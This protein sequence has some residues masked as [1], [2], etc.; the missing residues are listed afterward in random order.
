MK[1]DEVNAISTAV[2]SFATIIGLMAG[3]Y[4]SMKDLNMGLVY[5]L[6]FEFIFINIIILFVLWIRRKI[7]NES[8]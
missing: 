2:V 7:N 5:I 6:L 1:F 4:F 3:F 8:T